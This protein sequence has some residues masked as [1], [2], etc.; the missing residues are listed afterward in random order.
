MNFEED[1]REFVLGNLPHDPGC[2]VEL[3]AKTP[4]DLL[5]IYGNW[6]SRL[7]S[8]EPRRVHRS[9]ALIANLL[10]IDA[11]YKAGLD[12]II[13][14]LENGHDVTPHLS[15]GIRYGYK[16]PAMAAAAR[17]LTYY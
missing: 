17:T 14:K 8:M 9:K 11:Q 5:I 6:R 3:R 10:S 4:Q 7:V 16:P 12:A 2:T 13:S 1:I 15:R